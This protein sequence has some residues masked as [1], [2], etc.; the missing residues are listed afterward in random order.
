MCVEDATRNVLLTEVPA[1]LEDAMRTQTTLLAA[2]ASITLLASGDAFAQATPAVAT[3]WTFTTTTQPSTFSVAPAPAIDAM[4]FNV[5]ATGVGPTRVTRMT[6]VVKGTVH[7]SE[8][9]NFQLV[10][11]PAGLGS[12]GV[13]VGSNAGVGFAPPG[14]TSIVHIDLATPIDFQ[15]NFT[16]DFSLKMDVNG[17]R[18]YFFTPRLQTV[19]IESAGVARFVSE[20]GDLPLQGD[21]IYVN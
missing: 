8:V 11:Y 4:V 16:G 2:V 17:A 9:A 15:G 7:T 5:S 21:M 12:P 19:T 14:K 10:Y 3:P 18:S 13:V 20:T 6:F 1:V